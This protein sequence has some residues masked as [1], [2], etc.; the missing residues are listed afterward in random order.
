MGNDSKIRT[1]GD[2]QESTP[3][4]FLLQ[5]KSSTPN[6]IVTGDDSAQLSF[7]SDELNSPVE[8][9]DRVTDDM[10]VGESGKL[11]HVYAAH[12]IDLSPEMRGK[13]SFWSAEPIIKGSAAIHVIV[14]YAAGILAYK[15]SRDEITIVSEAVARNL[16]TISSVNVAIWEAVWVLTGEV[17]KSPSWP[18]PWEQ[19]IRWVTPDMVIGKRLNILY[20]KLVGYATFLGK[21]EPAAKA[22]G[23]KQEELQKYRDL[24]LDPTKV[25]DTLKTLSQWKS[26]R[27]NEAI[28]AGIISSIWQ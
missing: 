22:F 14:K 3:A 5:K 26:G 4:V 25:H 24:V 17:K 10:L 7:L 9:V 2:S 23:V 20:N 6:H 13:T 27:W 18:E 19:P 1:A 21:G 16:K 15:I 8:K 11:F 12:R 28:C